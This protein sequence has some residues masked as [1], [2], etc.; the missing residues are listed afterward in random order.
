MNIRSLLITSLAVL[1]MSIVVLIS[2]Q[3]ISSIGIVIIGGVLFTIAGGVNLVAS[4]RNSS[5]KVRLNRSSISTFFSKLSSIAAITLG[6]CMLVFSSTF[7]T[8][9]NFMFG[10]LILFAAIYQFYILLRYHRAKLLPGWL[11]IAPILMLATSVILFVTNKSNNDI[12]I[13]L[14]TGIALSIFGAAG[15]IESVYLYRNTN[16]TQPQA[17]QLSNQSGQ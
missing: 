15:I 6:I 8:L 9:V 2:Y 14:T 16:A 11:Y 12:T 3:N 7:A 1:A 10:L 17:V 5:K 4:V 13:M